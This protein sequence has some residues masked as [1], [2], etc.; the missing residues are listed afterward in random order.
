MRFTGE[1]LIFPKIWAKRIEASASLDRIDSSKGYEQGNVQWVH[2]DIN[3]MKQS[4]SQDK[5]IDWCKKVVNR[6]VYDADRS[7][8]HVCLC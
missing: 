5:F 7:D 3:N 8:E 6:C 2:K 1:L 4:F